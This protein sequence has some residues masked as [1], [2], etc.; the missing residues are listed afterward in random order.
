MDRVDEDSEERFKSPVRIR[1]SGNWNL[2]AEIERG[3][4]AETVDE[5]FL[6][7]DRIVDGE[8]EVAAIETIS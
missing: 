6:F 1:R 7:R 3:V 5:P 4:K 8:R 2:T